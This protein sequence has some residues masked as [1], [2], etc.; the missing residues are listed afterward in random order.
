MKTNNKFT[1]CVSAAALLF[2]VA[3]FAACKEVESVGDGILMTGTSANPLITFAIDDLPSSYDVSVSST[4]VVSSDVPVHL[5]VDPSLVENYNAQMNT[6]YFPIPEG[7]YTISGEEVVIRSGSAVST[8]VKVSVVDDSDFVPGR[9]YIIPITIDDADMP[10]I[11]ASRTMYL[12]VSRTLHFSAPDVGK[13][14]MSYQFLFPDP[15]TSLPV[16]TFEVKIYA[17]RFRDTGAGG[18][19]RV[20]SFGGDERSVEGGAIDDGGFK[21]DQVLLRFNEGTNEPNQLSINSK[22]G[23]QLSSVTR[24]DANRWYNIAVVCD[25]NIFSLYID[26][27]LDAS[28]AASPYDYTLYGVQ[29]GM[30][31]AGYQSSQLFYGRLGEMR[32]WTRPLSPTELKASLCGVDPDT[33]GLVA[34]WPMNEGE[35]NTFHDLS[36][37]HRDIAYA[38]NVSLDWKNDDYNKC[39]E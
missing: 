19:I 30:P 15:I 29:I 21:C 34:Y 11:A 27:E 28:M 3:N 13:G 31:S 2:A 1:L 25:G 8:S 18:T 10:I 20:C 12:K 39:V 33:N 38:A 35:G 24:F 23:N 6:N 22:S 36:P 7:A 26:G 17:D 16:F 4:G 9:V 5:S 14:A 32:L 37:N